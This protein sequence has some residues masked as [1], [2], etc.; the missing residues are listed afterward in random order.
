MDSVNFSFQENSG[1]FK[2]LNPGKLASPR[3]P[4][5]VQGQ[6]EGKSKSQC[7]ASW[8]F[9]STKSSWYWL[10]TH[11]SAIKSARQRRWVKSRPKANPNLPFFFDGCKFHAFYKDEEAWWRYFCFIQEIKNGISKDLKYLISYQILP[12]LI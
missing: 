10:F 12:N 3:P 6:N 7:K 4:L 11:F 2:S 9:N 8:P 1:K 5:L